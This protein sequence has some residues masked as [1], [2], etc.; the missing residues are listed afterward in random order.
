MLSFTAA[1]KYS[2]DDWRIAAI[3][4]GAIELISSFEDIGK[5]IGME[6]DVLK[7]EVVRN[8]N[9]QIYGSNIKFD[10]KDK[11][12]LTIKD[13][14]EPRLTAFVLSQENNAKNKER[15]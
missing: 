7:T 9:G 6:G 13:Y 1:K 14:F 3:K 2:D 8:W 11:A 12:E 15:A 10:S 5:Y 4:W